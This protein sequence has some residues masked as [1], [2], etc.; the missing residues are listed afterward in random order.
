MNAVCGTWFCNLE[1]VEYWM[2]V[3]EAAIASGWEVF[4]HEGDNWLT[5]GRER[6]IVS[7]KDDVLLIPPGLPV[8]YVVYSPVS[9]LMEGGMLWD[10]LSVLET[11]RSI[12]WTRED[13]VAT[14]KDMAYQLPR[15]MKILKRLVYAR[16]DKSTGTQ[17][18][19][20]CLNAI[21]IAM[22]ASE[23][24]GCTADRHPAEHCAN[25]AGADSAA[26]CGVCIT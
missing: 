10:E 18:S 4:K 19:T 24:S 6:L 23:Q 16:T 15:M 20:Q 8:V 1:G 12:A 9:C 7:K 3:P 21:E 2:I 26:I 22:Q 17:S 11:L 14:N 13:G 5:G 25:V